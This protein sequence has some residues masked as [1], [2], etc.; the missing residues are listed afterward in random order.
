MASDLRELPSTISGAGVPRAEARLISVGKVQPGR[1]FTLGR[2]GAVIGRGAD[3]EIAVDAFDVSRRHARIAPDG[4]GSWIIEDLQSHNGTLVNGVAVERKA[5]AFGDRVQLGDNALFIF[6][7]QDA[8]EE[9]L[10]ELQKMEVVGQLASGVAHDFNNLFAA[11]Q[12]N[13]L[14]LEQQLA[15]PQLDRAAVD[16]CLAES[17]VALASAVQ[18]SRRLLEISRRVEHDEAIVDLSQLAREVLQICARAFGDAIAIQAEIDPRLEVLGDRAQ[19]HQVLMNLC[20]NAREAIVARSPGGTLTLTAR[21]ARLSEIAPRSLVLAPGDQVVVLSVSDDGEGMSEQVLARIFEPFFTTK[22]ERGGTGLGLATAFHVVRRHGGEIDASSSPGE[23]TTFRVLLP[24]ATAEKAALT[25]HRERTARGS[26][27][28]TGSYPLLPM[29]VLV[30]D[31]DP[32]FLSA[33]ARLLGSWGYEA[34]VCSSG[35]EAVRVLEAHLGEVGCAILDLAMPV[36]TGQETLRI[37]RSV[38]PTLRV[39]L[40]SGQSSEEEVADLLPSVE[41]FLPKPHEP[42]A[43]RALLARILA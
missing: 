18:L 28:D 3:A 14:F 42:E 11:L 13:L 29:V 7:R 34:L 22:R 16:A 31:D 39:I 25:R 30:I 19:L 33:T 15:G 20:I 26:L 6:T 36:L 38:A 40:T 37:L 10:L 32:S 5:L 2:R 12:T 27:E 4:E 43:L 1:V 9:K 21:R 35:P 8:V 24:L 23:G 41:G 17:K